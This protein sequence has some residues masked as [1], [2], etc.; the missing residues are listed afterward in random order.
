MGAIEGGIRVPAIVRW[1]KRIKESSQVH[2]PTTLMDLLPTIKDIL[3]E[4][5]HDILKFD[6]LKSR[7]RC[8]L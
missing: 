1:P 3:E 5:N 4:M 2:A 7:D 6:L 8:S